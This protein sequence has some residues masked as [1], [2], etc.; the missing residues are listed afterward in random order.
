ML[1]GG[2][3]FG[4]DN[5]TAEWVGNARGCGIMN[6]MVQFGDSTSSGFKYYAINWGS[7]TKLSLLL[8]D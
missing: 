3:I 7:R 5:R 2:T 4:T 6:H 1:T 8:S